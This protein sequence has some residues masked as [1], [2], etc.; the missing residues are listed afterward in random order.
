VSVAPEARDDP[1]AIRPVAL[2]PLPSSGRP[3]VDLRIESPRAASA[4]CAVVATRWEPAAVRRVRAD[5]RAGWDAGLIVATRLPGDPD[6]WR[7]AR[8][9]PADPVRHAVWVVCDEVGNLDD[10]VRDET[11]GGPAA[12]AVPTEAQLRRAVAAAVRRLAD[13]GVPMLVALD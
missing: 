5:A 9:S 13:G 2:R 8:P 1:I 12:P 11:P 7:F 4:P 3:G 10:A 6:G